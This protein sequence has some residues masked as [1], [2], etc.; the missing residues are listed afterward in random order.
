MTKQTGLG[1]GDEFWLGYSKFEVPGEH[2]GENV[3][4]QLEMLGIGMGGMGGMGEE[5]ANTRD[6]I[7]L[8]AK[9][10]TDSW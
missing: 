6:P 10:G 2:S 3:N 7:S 1:G 5:G 9:A 4:R 8:V